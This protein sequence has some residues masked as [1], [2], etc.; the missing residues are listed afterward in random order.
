MGHFFAE[1]FGLRRGEIAAIKQF[2]VL[3]MYGRQWR[4]YRYVIIRQESQEVH[5]LPRLRQRMQDGMTDSQVAASSLG[6]EA[7]DDVVAL[8]DKT[9]R[10]R[11]TT[12]K[13]SHQRWY[14]RLVETV[15]YRSPIHVLALRFT[16][17]YGPIP[18]TTYAC[19]L[20]L[21]LSTI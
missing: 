21:E 2:N 11:I 5:D 10:C 15:A 4:A 12:P 6:F 9:Q 17:A 16:D 19:L 18:K 14:Y 20:E 8:A 13:I 1:R 7:V 3:A